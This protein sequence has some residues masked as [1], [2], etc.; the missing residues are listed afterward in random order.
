MSDGLVVLASIF[1]LMLMYSATRIVIALISRRPAESA[2]L[3]AIENQLSALARQ[4][5]ELRESGDLREQELARLADAQR[6]TDALLG[7]GR[8]H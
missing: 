7:R 8:G 6:F 5:E 2:R 4:I 3:A 1:A